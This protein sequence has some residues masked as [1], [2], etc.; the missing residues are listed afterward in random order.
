MTDQPIS[1]SPYTETTAALFERLASGDGN[2]ALA[3]GALI[4]VADESGAAPL[5]AV[6]SRFREALLRVREHEGRDLEDEARKLSLEE[7]RG[8]LCSRIFPRLADES[9]IVL[10]HGTLSDPEDVLTV[11]PALWAEVHARRQHLARR[12]RET[13]EHPL[14]PR[15]A[16]P[17]AGSVLVENP[18][19][20]SAEGL[21]KVY[22][23]RRVVNDV[24]LRVSQ[25][26]IVGL[27]GPNGAGK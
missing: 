17:A 16:T 10:P 21:I 9:A 4:E 1:D 3:L 7:V 25:G 23:G 18:S 19:V 8:H 12:L 24:A 11:A 6:T 22:R 14:Q 20:L 5:H 2:P 27:L 15:T 13:G 26:E